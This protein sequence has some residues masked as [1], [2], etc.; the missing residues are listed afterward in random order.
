MKSLSDR[1]VIT[2]NSFLAVIN[3]TVRNKLRTKSFVI[4]S[5]IFALIISIGVN[6][7]Y[8][9]SLFND[10][11]GSKT[12]NVG[13]IE[14]NE[15]EITEALKNYYERMDQSDLKMVGFPDAGSPEANE[16]TLKDAMLEKKIK[17]YIVLAPDEAGGFP[18]VT[19]K[20]E[21]MFDTSTASALQ[22]GLQAVKL[23]AVLQHAGL[24]EEQKQE[25]FTPVD[26]ETMQIAL[27]G[28]AAAGE[29]KD[30]AQSGLSMGFV[31]AMMIVLFMGIFVTSQLIASEITAEKS[32]RVM[33]ILVT[34][35]APLKQMFGKITGMFIVGLLQIAFYV[36]VFLVNVNLP[37]NVDFLKNFNI[38]L[39][40]I[41]P[42]LYVYAILFFLTGYFLYAT[43]YAAVGSIVSRTEDLAQALMPVTFLSLGGFYIGIFGMGTPDAMIVKVASFIPF[44][45]PFAMFL[46]IG[47]ASPMFWEIALS[48]VILFVS[49]FIF[50][51]LSA[52][53]YRTGVLMYGKRPTFK[54]LRK[55]MKAY[56]V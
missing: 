40:D 47:L 4:T 8:I 28:T 32:S 33:E 12:T 24:T 9:I 53:I 45:S 11:D 37:H 48:F 38:H 36:A 21:E 17:G 22:T 15:P 16:Q 43:L 55:A 25:L 23:E 41:D 5:I 31:Y 14:S 6:L 13:Y 46:R 29:G 27:T 51:W 2:L 44:F 7:P 30:A 52:K 3:F 18:H 39:S 50:G 34:S 20:S 10:D 26:V 35:V 1:W 56:K 54:E 19:Y 49:I 42:R